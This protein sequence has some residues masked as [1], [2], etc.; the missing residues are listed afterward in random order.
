MARANPIYKYINDKGQSDLQ[1][2]KSQGPIQQISLI[3]LKWSV[4][5]FM[6][7][8]ARMRSACL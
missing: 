2:Y 7:I 5:Y 8:D 4:G 6:R 1:I 3:E